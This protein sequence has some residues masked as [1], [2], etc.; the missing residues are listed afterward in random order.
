MA[1]AR[2]PHSDQHG[3]AL[4]GETHTDQVHLRIATVDL[5]ALNPFESLLA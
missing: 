2:L 5:G 3:L 1:S 4:A